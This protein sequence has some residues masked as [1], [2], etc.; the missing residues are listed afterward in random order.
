MWLSAS[1]F[2]HQ[3][4][5]CYSPVAFGKKTDKNGDYIRKYLPI[6]KKYPAKYI[7]EPWEAPLSLQKTAKCVIGIDYPR[8]IV[9]HTKVVKINMEKMKTAYD[10]NKK[11]IDQVLPSSSKTRPTE[12]EEPKTKKQKKIGKFFVPEN[13][14]LPY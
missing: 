12:A 13:E 7:Y 8:P 1:A 3:F 4:W 11:G 6:L 14:E 5:R 9:D 2:F 10:N